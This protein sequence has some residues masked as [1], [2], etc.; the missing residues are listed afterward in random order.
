MNKLPVYILLFFAPALITAQDSGNMIIDADTT[1]TVN[2]LTEDKS[3]NATVPSDTLVAYTPKRFESGFKTKY[4]GEEFIYELKPQ[5]K[6]NWQ[7]FLDWLSKVLND[8]F[9]FGNSATNTPAYAI[10]VRILLG[11]LLLFVVYLIVKAIV[12]K[13]GSFR[14]FGRSGKKI[15]VQNVTEG[16]IHQMDF[17][18]LI[19]STK[20]KQDYRLGVRY[21]YL[22]LL[23][24]LS[25]REII[26]WHWD[27][28]NTDYRY[29]IKDAGLRKDFEYLSY[30]YDYS[31]YGEFPINELAFGKAEKAFLKTINTL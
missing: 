24:K 17:R 28:T 11:L 4:K 12:N 6:T 15:S 5:A 30:L 7:R 10:I 16:D 25:N 31:W 27:K 23:K 26:D 1:A 21:Y 29:E 3:A 22:W 8:I 13:E 20:Q 14:I 9:S 19:E 18:Q 2:F